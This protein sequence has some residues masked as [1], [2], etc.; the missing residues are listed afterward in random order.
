MELFLFLFW[1]FILGCLFLTIVLF[2]LIKISDK[3]TLNNYRICKSLYTDTYF[4]EKRSWFKWNRL[5]SSCFLKVSDC[6]VYILKC[7]GEDKS[8]IKYV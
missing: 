2:I 7:K 1:Y 6:T 3:L 4:I 8:I 5:D